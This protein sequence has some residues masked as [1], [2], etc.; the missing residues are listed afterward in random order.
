MLFTKLPDLLVGWPPLRWRIH[1][2][3]R[4]PTARPPAPRHRPG[5]GSARP[6]DPVGRPPRV[7]PP[8]A[9]KHGGTGAIG[10]ETNI[11]PAEAPASTK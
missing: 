2:A 3:P 4:A 10:A 11:G 6:S 1:S 9:R 5:L 7:A 8:P